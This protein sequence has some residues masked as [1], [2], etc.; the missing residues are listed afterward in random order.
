[1]TKGGI[2]S[3]IKPEQKENPDGAEPK[4][5]FPRAEAIFHILFQIGFF[6]AFLT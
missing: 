5:D 4:R 3:E 2:Y 1:M 6:S